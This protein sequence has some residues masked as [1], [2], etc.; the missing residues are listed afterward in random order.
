MRNAMEMPNTQAGD[1]L[2][3]R[4][5]LVMLTNSGA[6]GLNLVLFIWTI[7]AIIA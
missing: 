1:W 7:G 6:K 2:G 4:L 3:A 5:V